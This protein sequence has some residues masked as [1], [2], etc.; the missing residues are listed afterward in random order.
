M[1]VEVGRKVGKYTMRD[2]G[3]MAVSGNNDVDTKCRQNVDGELNVK[4]KEEENSS[5]VDIV[6]KNN[7]DDGVVEERSTDNEKGQEIMED[8]YNDD[9]GRGRKG[10]GVEESSTEDGEGHDEM[11]WVAAG[12]VETN[13]CL[14]SSMEMREYLNNL[15]GDEDIDDFNEGEKDEEFPLGNY[16]QPEYAIDK[17]RKYLYR[18]LVL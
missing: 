18:V 9:G 16:A 8:N 10:D 2:E 12:V 3:N 7:D 15:S 6:A 13:E 4:S 1:T 11:E 14:N 5:R 17:L